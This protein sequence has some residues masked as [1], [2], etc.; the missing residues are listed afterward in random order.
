MVCGD[1]DLPLPRLP[2]AWQTALSSVTGARPMKRFF[3]IVVSVVGVVVLSPLFAMAAVLVK[4]TSRGPVL[5][6]QQRIGRGFR[7]FFI[8]KFRS[9]VWDAP[10][11]G[12]PITSGDDPRITR[13]G[14][15]LR[16]TKIDELPQLINVLKGDMSL[17]GPRPEVGK[18]VEMFRPDYEEIL[19][20]RPGI[21]DLASIVYRDEATLLGA[22]TDPEDE[23]VRRI[24]PEKVRLAKEYLRRSSF[25]FDLTLMLKTVWNL[26]RDWAPLSSRR[27]GRGASDGT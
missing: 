25:F 23:Y 21:T 15:I 16:M 4:L 2:G 17:V 7:P 27:Q 6:R 13:V 12:G 8:M 22:V 14:R 1:S 9:M 5:F 18:Y 3:D 26:A 24:L 10:R 20:V 19:E 11:R